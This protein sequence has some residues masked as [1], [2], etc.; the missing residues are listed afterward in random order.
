ME[1][2]LEVSGVE[3]KY[4]GVIANR[5]VSLKVRPASIHAIIGEN[6][7]GK[8]TLM[9]I[10]YGLVKPDAGNIKVFGTEVNFKSPEDAIELGLGMV[11]Q[12]FKLAD[13]L[14]V[15]ENIILGSE[16]GRAGFLIDY[17]VAR[18]R[19]L[20]LSEKYGIDVDPDERLGNLGVG[21]RQRVEIAKVLYRGAK[22][23]I[24]DEPTAVL[25]PQEVEELFSNLR[26]LVK[27]GLTI[28]FI[29]HKLDEV[30]SIAD[31]IT[32]MRQGTTVA[33][34][35]PKETNK[36]K[37][38]E[39]MVGGELP[40]PRATKTKPSEN[41]VLKVSA[42]NYRRDDGREVLKGINLEVREGEIVGLAGVEGN[43]QEELIELVMGLIKPTGGKVEV[44][45]LDTAETLTRDI[46]NAGVA[47]IPQDRSRDGLLLQ[48]SLW[49]NRVLGHQFTPP[50]SKGV[51]VN[52]SEAIK[53]AR[54]VIKEFDVR[55]PGVN[56]LASALSG[57]NQ[58][59]FI[60]GRELSGNP[61]FVVA[62]QPTRGVDVGAQAVIW[63]FLVQAR[64]NGAGV[65]LISADLDELFALS[66]RLTVIYSGSIVA[67]MAPSST[68]PEKLGLA[69]TG[70]K[71]A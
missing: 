27:N 61:K 6:G 9:K 12:H 10:L 7:A 17:K 30:L 48:A 59:K 33:T 28:L 45:G 31:E 5:D 21:G 25:V 16:P 46:R 8:S 50:M 60:V 4:P 52:R 57:G 71:S 54:R 2:V 41:R 65:L 66:D 19:V 58:Q 11:H 18:Q 51:W 67:D 23:L 38:A 1:R 37:L 43:G 35:V 56:V 64:A 3:K 24:L 63:D 20:E 70:A 40:K 39:L 69:M 34:L 15:L 55:T 36:S 22:I 42:A 49:E 53:D 62:A 47:Y 14:S 26:D 13:N 29:S 68:T 32:V 44:L